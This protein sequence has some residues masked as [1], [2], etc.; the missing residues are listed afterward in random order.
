MWTD[1]RYAFR[2]LRASPVFA[3]T[4]ILTL[5]LGIGANTAIFSV[6]NSIMLNPTGVPD[7]A[8]LVALRIKY[9]KISHLAN[10]GTSA[11]DFASARDNKALFANAATIDY[12][13]F[14]Y[15]GGDR[16]ERLVGAWVSWQFLSTMGVRPALGRDF[17]PEED[18]PGA[19][20]VVILSHSAWNRLFGGDPSIVG[21]PISLNQTSHQVIGVMGPEFR[22][23][24][25]ADL[26]TPLGFPPERYHPA[27]RFDQHLFTVARLKP[28]VSYEQ[29]LA[30]TVLMGQQIIKA[31]S[32]VNSGGWS[33]FIR[34]FTEQ[35][36]G[37]FRTPLLV[38][39]GAVG[40]VLL[41]ACSNIAGL[42]L[43]RAS[44]RAKEMAV[45]AAL[46][47]GHAHLI[48]QSMAESS[49][50]AAAGGML[51]IGLAFAGI[52]LL[53]MLAPEGVAQSVNIAVDH[54][55]LLFTLGLAALAG[56]WFGLAPAIQVLRVQDY[57]MLKEGGRSGT[58]SR[59]RQ[60]TR[61]VLVTGEIALALVLL[62]GAG[63]FLRSLFELRKVDTGFQPSGVMS[64]RFSLPGAQFGDEK[65][66]GFYLAVMDRLS[67]MPGIRAAGG[68]I[69]LPFS[70]D[71]WS[72]SFEIDG[73]PT[74]PGQPGPHGDQ[75]YVLPGYF[76][77]M[78]IPLL[79]GRYMTDQDRR[80]GEN[81][82]IIDDLLARTYFPNE[83]PIG[84]RL[85]RGRAPNRRTWTIVGVVG[86]VRHNELSSDTTG[87]YFLS[88]YQV[89]P[90]YMNLVV[91]SAAGPGAARSAILEAVRLTDPNQPV[92][93]L[94]TMDERV[95]ESLGTLRFA[96]RLLGLFAAFA[97]L[98]AALGLFGLVSYSVT[99]RTQEIG[100]R[101]ALG[102]GSSD[103]LKLILGQ[104]LRLLAAG[105]I[106]GALGAFALARLVSSQLFGVRPFDPMTF[107]GT[108]AMLA[109]VSLFASY[110]PARRAMRV[111][112]NI[113]LRYE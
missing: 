79:K 54:R 109:G 2:T 9:D 62:V 17:R 6:V 49:V 28:G 3:I 66:A 83:D 24:A 93:D 31:E 59:F 42:L 107:F 58:A 105:V 57:E 25:R 91:Q 106:L 36:A 46:G 112:P 55:V 72:G 98:M 84:R 89:P 76:Q 90:Q 14:N 81:A 11:A 69:P 71:N 4:A 113:A 94:K 82:A 7:P 51:G 50:L 100:I 77:A 5:A 39:L 19:N 34:P 70:G 29:A 43:A 23:P 74:P 18:Q 102:A 27:R 37:N 21:K 110:L 78:G 103:V 33:M 97:L 96:V 56:L 73:K 104:G 65:R 35:V 52:R 26:W 63:L 45:R 95:S 40:F 64:A 16:P 88:A 44:G 20:Q 53:L 85:S 92:F 68:V 67:K 101:V 48:R 1:L 60:R 8:T 86:H 75:R 87:A 32:P 47:A 38:L 12:G 13:D 15:T 41:I 30:G 108:A 111:D 99:Q 10:I 61:S 22:F 80:G